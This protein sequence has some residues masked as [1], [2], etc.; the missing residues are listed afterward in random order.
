[1]HIEGTKINST[2]VLTEGSLGAAIDT[3]DSRGVLTSGQLS[4]Y[5]KKV[6]P[7]IT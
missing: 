1:M 4:S 5:W 6:Q 2:F 3:D 7:L